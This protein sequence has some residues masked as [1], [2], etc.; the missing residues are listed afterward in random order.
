VIS[1]ILRVLPRTLVPQFALL[2]GIAI[3]ILGIALGAYL[4]ILIRD[5]AESNAVQSARVLAGIGIQPL[6][7]QSDLQTGL[8]PD[9]VAALDSAVNSSKL[10]GTELAR[11]NIWNPEHRVVYSNDHSLI[12][13]VFPTSDELNDAPNGTSHSGVSTPSKA[14]NESLIS[15][16]QILEVYVPLRLQ[17][18]STP[19]GAFEIYIPYRPI[20][21]GILRDELSVFGVLTLG[22][23]LLYA[24][25]FRIVTQAARRLGRQ[26]EE[27]KRQTAER[28][29][30]AHHDVL[31]LL[32]N[33]TLFQ[34][35]LRE[36]IAVR[37]KTGAVMIM[38]LDR[39]QEI[40]DTLG[41]H[42]GDSVLIAVARRLAAASD[43]SLVARL[44]G[45]EFAVL[46]E[47]VNDRK[48]AVR[49]AERLLAT[50]ADQV[51]LGDLT[52]D[53][54][55][56]IGVALFPEHGTD[57]DSLMQRAD[58]AMYVAKGNKRGYEVYSPESDRYA[59]ERLAL[60]A[61]LHRALNGTGLFLTY[62]PKIDLK[63]GRISGVEALIRWQHPTR[64][65]IQPD[66]F[67]PLAEHTGLI[68]DLTL[69]VL[70]TALA[71]SQAWQRQGIH[72]G[73]A[74]NLSV[75]NLLDLDLPDQ[76]A[77]L[78]QKWDVPAHRLEL[79]ITETTL[80][81]DPARA[82]SVIARL[83]AMGI[84]L[85]IDDF[86]TGYS[87]LVFLKQL[88]VQEIKIDKSFVLNMLADL[89]DGAIVRSIIDLAKNLGL[90]VVAEGVE[91]EGIMQ[92]LTLR[93]CTTAQGFFI[94]RPV[95]AD[96]L[97]E[98]LVDSSY[99]EPKAA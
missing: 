56:S 20:A 40:N 49:F 23:L 11:I 34:E 61:D 5:H 36:V 90:D 10:L 76:V 18:S 27:L 58:I 97:T 79:E 96:R 37:G 65:L 87:S 38:D 89:G 66:D 70:D 7:S 47:A 59:P 80:M 12:W 16:G 22:L 19:D 62:Q 14:E 99:A 88:P 82:S 86:G 15:F 91:S 64:G 39:F 43:S 54:R 42:N 35:R 17:G 51:T 48:Q 81:E 26:A 53:V 55:G 74:V 44:G 6:I 78:L 93:G 32:P 3:L 63:R 31:T 25:L 2:S 94:S 30:A 45:D 13:K 41:H 95:P 98:W 68:K 24:L 92:E 73:I 69:W 33:R 4:N 75:R 85:S 71:Q 21:A 8:T 57:A 83:N 72:L 84:R 77:R 9:R 46:L 1:R 60:I 50:F 67:I 29:Y 28:E 52:L